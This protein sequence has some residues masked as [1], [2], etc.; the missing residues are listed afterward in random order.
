MLGQVESTRVGG[1]GEGEVGWGVR[2]RLQRGYNK[3][4][5]HTGGGAHSYRLQMQTIRA[6]EESIAS[7]KTSQNSIIAL[8]STRRKSQQAPR[9]NQG[10][11][12]RQQAECSVYAFHSSDVLNAM[13]WSVTKFFQLGGGSLLFLVFSSLYPP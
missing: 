10:I 5:E 12:K 11:G 4:G 8:Q 2:G 1:G 7:I 9:G 6:G 13:L 3:R